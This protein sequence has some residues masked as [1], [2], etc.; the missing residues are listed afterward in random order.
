[1][2]YSHFIC[3]NCGEFLISSEALKLLP[4][5]APVTLKKFS[6]ESKRAYLSGMILVISERLHALESQ[7]ELE[8]YIRSR[9]QVFK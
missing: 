4:L 9:Q 6:N 5:C 2:N 8:G 3:A 7:I 1:M